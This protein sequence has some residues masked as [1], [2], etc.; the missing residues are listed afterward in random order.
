[1]SLQTFCPRCNAPV[2]VHASAAEQTI[3]C[4]NCKSPFVVPPA[5]PTA[6]F[7]VIDGET[8]GRRKLK[9]YGSAA[10]PLFP[11]SFHVAAW[12]AIVTMAVCWIFFVIQNAA[13][14]KRRHDIMKEDEESYKRLREDVRGQK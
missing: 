8:E 5:S 6:P 11:A 4:P 12:M 1:M 10:R 13:Y 9:Q 3:G 7:Q 2:I 14:F